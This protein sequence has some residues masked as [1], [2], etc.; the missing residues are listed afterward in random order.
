[1]SYILVLWTEIGERVGY[2]G[3]REFCYVWLKLD[4]CEC[5]AQSGI[6]TSLDGQLC[7]N[8]WHFR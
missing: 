4:W 1:M 6:W 8:K 5:L 2:H 7:W 3:W